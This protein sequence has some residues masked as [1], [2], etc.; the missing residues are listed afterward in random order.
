MASEIWEALLQM[1]SLMF[2]GINE[3][4]IDRR[5]CNVGARA[6]ACNSPVL[7]ETYSSSRVPTTSTHGSLCN[8]SQLL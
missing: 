7:S 5:M 2:I 6:T 1:G 8:K 4:K 3:S